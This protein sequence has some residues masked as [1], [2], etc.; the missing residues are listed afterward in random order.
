IPTSKK[1]DF[2]SNFWGSVHDS[3]IWDILFFLRVSEQIHFN[4]SKKGYDEIKR[5]HILWQKKKQFLLE[6][7]FGVW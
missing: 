5:R 6:A 3:I 1:L 4:F 7:V 2:W